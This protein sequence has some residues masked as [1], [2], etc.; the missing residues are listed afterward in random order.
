[1]KLFLATTSTRPRLYEEIKESPYLLESFYYFKE[2]QAPLVKS[3]KMFLVDSGAFTFM[4]SGAAVD[5]DAYVTRYIN[6]INR[7]GI[8]YFFELDIDSVVGY[9]RVK[10]IRKRLEAETGRQCIPVWHKSRGMDEYLRL[11][12]EYPYIAI[13]GFAIGTIKRQEYQFIP[14]L[15]RAAAVRGTKVHGLGFTPANVEEYGFFSTDSSTWNTGSRYAATYQFSY[16]RMKTIKRPE[17]KRLTNHLELDRYNLR[18][19]IKFQ[20]YLDRS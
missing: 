17:G 6:F 2:W 18:Q 12:E 10:A 11:C 15:L 8:Q 5:W 4:S 7:L 16:G 9:E 1:V 19:W 13:G 20:K 3:A 14:R